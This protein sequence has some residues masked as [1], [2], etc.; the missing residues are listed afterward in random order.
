MK[1]VLWRAV[2]CALSASAASAAGLTLTVTHDLDAARP[3]AHVVVPFAD[4]A[5]LAPSLRMFHVVVRDPKG[6]ALP[7]QITNYEHDHKGARY[8]D[9]VFQYDFAKDEKSVAFTLEAVEKGTP[10]ETP[11]AYARLVPE[12]HDDVAWENDRIAHRM[13]G[14]ALN[15]PAAGGERLRGSG[16]DVWGKRV[17]YPIVDRWYAKGHDQFHEDAEGEGLDLY[18]IGGSRGA[19]GTGIWDGAKLWTSDNFA[20]ARVLSNGPRRAA[21]RL[22][23]A[24]WDAGSAGSVSETKQFTVDCGRNFDTV[25]SV[26]DFSGSEAVVG[27]GVTEHPQAEGFPKTVMTKDPA[28]RWMSLWEVNKHGGLGVAV[29]LGAAETPAGFAYEA[30][31]KAPG[32]ANHLLLVKAKDGAPIRYFTGA[33]W[34][35]SGQFADRAAWETYVK[36][37]AA[38]AAKPFRVVVSVAP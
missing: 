7:L 6:R 3:G 14:L 32:N 35:G 26:F 10:P 2:L 13:Y 19:G 23:Y 22:A 38:R 33:G 11:C 25:D 1:D 28:G 15:S 31:A 29:I 37:H 18:S 12:R 34:S 8:D 21:F 30:P 17:A 5:A 36:D 16:I 4:I 20:S 24:P 27:V 9:L